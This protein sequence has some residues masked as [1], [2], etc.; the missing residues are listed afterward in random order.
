[1]LDRKKLFDEKGITQKQLMA[2][3]ECS[4][5]YASAL[6]N[7]K[8]AIGKKMAERL[9]DLYGFNVEDLMF[10]DDSSVGEPL[11]PY[12]KLPRLEAKP[13]RLADPFGLEAT[14]A[15][16]YTLA[17]GSEVM[18]ISVVP[19][20]AFGS[21]LRGY[22]DPEFYD[23]FETITIP[24]DKLHKGSYLAFEMAGNSMVNIENETMARKSLWP[25][26]KII[27]RHLRREQWQYKLHIHSNEAWIIVHRTEGIVVK[28]IIAHDIDTGMITLHSWNPDKEEYP[29]YDVHL[30]EVEQ[31]LNVV[32]PFGKMKPY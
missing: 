12:I 27:G 32:D 7:G 20:K 29:D 5:P 28:E 8:K 15:K 1:M 22:G 19:Q 9:R 10:S 11:M 14:G 26:Q 6:M 21:Y 2:D 23:G 25:G 4:Q 31:L 16:F 24:V 18:Q 30:D 3:L 17:D 13:L